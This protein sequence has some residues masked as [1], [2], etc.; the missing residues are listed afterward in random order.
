MSLPV[1]LA[2]W[3]YDRTHA[4]QTGAVRAEGI[5]LTYLPLPVEETFFRMLRHRE[6]DAAEM[7][8]SSYV[9]TLGQESPPFIA[10]PVF[11]SRAFRHSCVFVNENSG[12]REPKD[13]VGKVVGTP[14]FQ[15]TA[16]V[17]IRGILAEHHGVAIDSVRYRTGG[18]ESPNRPEKVKLTLPDGVEVEP[19][20]DGETLSAML[21]SGEIDAL[22]TARMPSSF[23]DRAPG[24]VRLFPDSRATETAYFEQTGIFP[25]MHVVALRREVHERHPWVAGELFK[26]FERSR[27][28]A[29]AGL[30]ETAALKHM[31]PWLVQEVE[32]TRTA[33]GDDFW[34]YG[35][36]AN[37]RVLEAFLGYSHAQGL[38]PRLLTPEEMFAPATLESFVI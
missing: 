8:M 26:A 32:V 13:L 10:I 19:L 15:M 35:L 3:D 2:C 27:K 33:L 25:I 38:S 36:Q 37:R 6:F 18:L 34:P 29:V 12:I 20:G 9:M 5:D 31:L 23:V 22:Y 7:S 11:P 17:W 1:T 14:E 28:E 30:Y 21:A 4:L 16:A 24:V